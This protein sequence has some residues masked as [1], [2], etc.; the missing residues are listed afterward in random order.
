MKY[1]KYA[2]PLAVL[3]FFATIPVAYDTLFKASA[4]L[5]HNSMVI[6]VATGLI[7][8]LITFLGILTA[9]WWAPVAEQSMIKIVE[10][11]R[12]PHP[13]TDEDDDEEEDEDNK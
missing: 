3:A 4:I 8:S 6:P 7:V 2:I 12:E 11:S 13:G 1:L 10:E 5:Y 9:E